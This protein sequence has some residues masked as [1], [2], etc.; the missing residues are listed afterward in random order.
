MDTGSLQGRWRIVSWSQDYDDGRQTHP[1]GDAL[2]GFI[3]YGEQ[4]M[5]C[6]ISRLPRTRFTTGG[7]WDATD[8]DKARA[9]DEYLTYAGRYEFDGQMVTHHIEQCIFPNW[10]GTSQRRKVIREGADAITLVARVEE[11]TPEARTAKLSWVRA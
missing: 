6:V 4:D 10:A 1:F 2:E 3:A 8:W 9:Y 5:F 7:Q 11:G